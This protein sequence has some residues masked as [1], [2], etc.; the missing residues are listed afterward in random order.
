MDGGRDRAG[1]RQTDRVKESKY[2]TVRAVTY[3]LVWSFIR[4]FTDRW[5]SGHR[6]RV[7]RWV[8][9]DNGSLGGWVG[10]C[11]GGWTVGQTELEVD[12]QTDR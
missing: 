9:T 7:I 4:A 6:Q 12:R 1:D 10:G 5:L 3:W 8:D 2:S 11:V